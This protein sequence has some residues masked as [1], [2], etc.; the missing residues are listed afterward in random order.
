MKHLVLALFAISLVAG[1]STSSDPADEN[2]GDIVSGDVFV[3]GDGTC[4]PQCEGKVCGDD[5]CGST[6]GDC[7]DSICDNGQCVAPPMD[8]CAGMCGTFSATASCKCDANCFDNGD[9]CDDICD[10]CTENVN[11]AARCE[12]ACVPNC[13]EGQECGGD[14]CGGFCG[15]GCAAEEA[16]VEGTCEGPNQ[17]ITSC[18]GMCGEWGDNT[19]CNCDAECWEYNDCCEDVCT[20][21]GDDYEQCDEPCEPVCAEGQECG[22]D[23]CGGTCGAGC[24]DG[25]TCN[26]DGLC[27]GGGCVSNCFEGQ[28]CGDNECGGTC[29][30]GCD[31]GETCNEGICET[32]CEPTCAEGQECGDDGCGGTCGA[33]CGLTEACDETNTCGPIDCFGVESEEVCPEDTGCQLNENWDG[34]Q[35]YADQS[36]G[37]PCGWGNGNCVEGLQCIDDDMTYKTSTCQPQ[38][39]KLGD[40]CGFGLEGCEDDLV[41]DWI[42]ADALEC[43][44]FLPEGAPCGLGLGTCADGLSC[45]PD[46]IENATGDFCY[47]DKGLGDVCGWGAGNCGEDLSCM[48]DE[49]VDEDQIPHCYEAN[50]EAGGTCGSGI[51][52]CASWLAC[53]YADDTAETGVC[54]TIGLPGDDCGDGIANCASSI[55]SCTLL[56]AD[57]EDAMCMALK[58]PGDA[59]GYGLGSCLSGL[60]CAASDDDPTVGVCEDSCEAGGLYGDGT[61]D[62]G[63]WMPDSDCFC[64]P[65]CD[66]K[67]CGS[68]GCGSTCGD[69][70]PEGEFCEA[71]VC[72]MASCAADPTLCGNEDECV[73]SADYSDLVCMDPAAE[74]EACLLGNPACEEGLS[75]LQETAGTGDSTC[76]AATAEEG[77]TC[78]FGAPACIDGM[79]CQWVGFEETACVAELDLGDD[80]LA[81]GAGPCPEGSACMWDS[82]DEDT[83]SCMASDQ[84]LGEPC[85]WG[86]GLCAEGLTC[87]YNAD[88]TQAICFADDLEQGEACGNLGQGD[89]ASPL[90]C[91]PENDGTTL[92]TCQPAAFV[93]EPCGYGVAYCQAG[94]S[95]I[96]EAPG[97]SNTICAANAYLFEACGDGIAGCASGLECI[98]G[99]VGG[100]CVDAC[101][102]YGYYGDGECDE[103]C[104]TFDA[105]DCL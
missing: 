31:D 58:W 68:D 32:A 13:A 85:Y 67:T 34:L 103:G 79:Q 27:D 55:S 66:G 28:E 41:C 75:C 12:P 100:S 6:C 40:V 105:D 63:C 72:A 1:C 81:E 33:G 73:L 86:L 48:W 36:E 11:I 90:L 25:W 69:E 37:S 2:T 92:G 4:V 80:C 71:G 9:C 91:T 76:F 77:D 10:V 102:F 35:C 38:T 20:F 45:W 60:E 52:A 19:T 99:G 83:A 8:S 89:C 5:G 22:D 104:L 18:E 39:G 46:A 30:P 53:N 16:C 94:M 62:D 50:I 57:G 54:I 44:D 51:G 17:D 61:C 74:G 65:D 24:D 29:G 93:D 14:G 21:C 97:S 87:Q 26:E 42:Q 98:D 43:M 70:C 49:A 95:C 56:T 84:E 59:C 23:G 101:V 78:A 88:A 7:G 3:G 96:A 64:T 15:P 47:A 82:E